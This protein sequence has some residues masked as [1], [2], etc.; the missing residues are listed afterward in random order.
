MKMENQ[1]AQLLRWRGRNGEA[2]KR[3]VVTCI[4]LGDLNITAFVTCAWPDL[5]QDRAGG[6]QAQLPK[7]NRR[8]AVGR[9][10][11]RLG[12]R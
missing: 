11:E 2:R 5:T 12:R 1:R 10:T 6:L 7:I 3:K 8:V 4:V 9:T